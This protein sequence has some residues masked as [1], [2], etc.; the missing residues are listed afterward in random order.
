M[1]YTWI[2]YN[3]VG[4]L[5]FLFFKCAPQAESVKEVTGDTGY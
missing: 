3:I 1:L 4:Q 5:Y 2:K